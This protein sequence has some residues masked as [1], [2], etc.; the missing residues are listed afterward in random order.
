M[1]FVLSQQVQ[2]VAY[3]HQ[4]WRNI[5]TQNLHFISAQNWVRFNAS[6]HGTEGMIGVQMQELQD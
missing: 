6:L 3:I 2:N 1:L 5:G 4:S